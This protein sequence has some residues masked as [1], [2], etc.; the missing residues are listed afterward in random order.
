MQ[1]RPFCLFS[2]RPKLDHNILIELLLALSLTF[3]DYRSIDLAPCAG[4]GLVLAVHT[5]T[6]ETFTGEQRKGTLDFAA[7]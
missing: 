4:S 2:L 7:S 3:L 5:T 6:K 1:S